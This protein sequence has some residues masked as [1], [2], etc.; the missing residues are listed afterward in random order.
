MT[1]AELAASI[2]RQVVEKGWPDTHALK[3]LQAEITRQLDARQPSLPP[4]PA[5][6]SAH[7][8]ISTSKILG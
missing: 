5:L 2:I 6:G 7:G 1:N 4:A 3:W 8:S